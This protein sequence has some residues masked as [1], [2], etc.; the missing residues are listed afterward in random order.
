MRRLRRLTASAAILALTAAGAALAGGS[1]TAAPTAARSGAATAAAP[2]ISLA[3]VKAHLTEFQRIADANGGSRAHGEPGFRASLDYIQGELDAVG[4]QTR[5]QS[6]TY[7][8]E[9]GY[10]LIADWPG[11]DPDQVL[12]AGAHLD[13]VGSGPGI[14]DNASGSAGILEVAL[15]VARTGHQ[16]DKHLRF[17]WWGAEEL[18]LV[19]SEYYVDSLSS[20]ERSRIDGYYNFDM[21]GSPNAGYFVYD[22]DDS[23]GTG[24]G[25]GPAGS[26][27]LEQVLEDYFASIGVPTR[28]TDF[29]GRSDYGPFIRVGIAAGGTFTGAEG[30]KTQAEADMWGG[31]AGRAYDPCYHSSCDTTSNIDDDALNRNADAIAHAMWTVGGSQAANDF[32]VAVSPDSGSVDAGAGVQTTVQTQT[33]RGSAQAVALSAEGLP[34][35]VTASFSPSTVTSGDA[36]TLTLNAAAGAPSGTYDITVTGTGTETTGTATYRLTVHGTSACGGLQ[37]SRTGTLSS[38][39]AEIQPDGS[40]YHSGTSGTHQACLDAPDGTDFDLYLQKWNG[41]SWSEVD[42]STSAGPDEEISYQGSSGYY[43]YRVHAYSGSGSYTL[44]YSTP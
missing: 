37:N 40:Y 31:T 20:T 33:T 36:A 35:G 14:N 8:G 7:F 16:P 44:G 34:N 6:F 41:W 18:G 3:D 38:G 12:M 22:G 39:G 15:E 11:G 25:P 42:S 32:S 17:A 30:R 21:I 28:G 24:S 10:N 27:H 13:S 26:A 19:G 1:A 2:D 9:T 5:V 4:F 43:R 23:D 29:N